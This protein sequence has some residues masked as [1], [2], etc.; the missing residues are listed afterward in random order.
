ME[1]EWWN[2]PI[3]YIKSESKWGLALNKIVKT[4]MV[5]MSHIE[6]QNDSYLL[7][8]VLWHHETW[9]GYVKAEE[10]RQKDRAD[11]SGF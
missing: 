1:N 9:V 2:A 4:T 7:K 3:E 8:I 10:K 6:L 11:K 5:Q